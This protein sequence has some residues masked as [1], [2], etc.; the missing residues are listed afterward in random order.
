MA[1]SKVTDM[2]AATSVNAAD[3]LYVV[4]SSA[5]KKL[6]M[7][8]LLANL[9]NTLTKFSG[10]LALSVGS[11]QTITNAGTI[12]ATKFLTTI[13]NEAGSFSLSIDNGSYDGQLKLVMC[14]SASGT[15]T[16]SANIA[17]ASIQ[18]NSRGD[19][20]LLIWYNNF[21]WVLGGTANVT[22]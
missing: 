15:S 8:T 3:V 14:T 17:G 6:S 9:P 5:D 10:L 18:F 11:P 20:A 1:D 22:L 13:S 21:W 16:L 7:S 2:T 4:Q 19:T 12:N